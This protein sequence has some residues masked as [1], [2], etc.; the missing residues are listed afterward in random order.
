MFEIGQQVVCIWDDWR[1]KPDGE[2]PFIPAVKGQVYTIKEWFEAYTHCPIAGIPI[3]DHL[4]LVFKE[5]GNTGFMSY[6]FRPVRKTDISIFNG[7]L[8]DP[9]V[10]VREDA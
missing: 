8:V 1:P 2:R 9:P 7:L 6:F 3:G 5:T 4:F 10:R